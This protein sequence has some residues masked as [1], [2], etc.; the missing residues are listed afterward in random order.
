MFQD[1]PLLA[2]L[3]QKIQEN[4]P[5]KEGTIKGTD[6]NFGFLEVDSKTSYFIPPPMMKKCMHGDKVVAFIRNDNDKESADPQ[7]LIEPS[8]TRALLGV[9]SYSKANLMSRL[10]TLK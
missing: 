6:K 9:L 8:L 3:K 2:Q 7:E 1:N 4:L 10:I 5:K